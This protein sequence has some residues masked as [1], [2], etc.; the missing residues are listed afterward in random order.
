M[1]DSKL[2]IFSRLPFAEFIRPRVLLQ[3]VFNSFLDRNG[4]VKS[5]TDRFPSERIS[6]AIP[7][8]MFFNGSSFIRLAT[9]CGDW[10]LHEI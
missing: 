2:N 4:R 9:L 10:V 8:N 6:L 1:K 3:K 7:L 5:T